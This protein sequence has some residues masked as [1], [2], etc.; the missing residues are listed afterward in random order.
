MT[1]LPFWAV[2]TPALTSIGLKDL[3][4]KQQSRH[5]SLTL[6]LPGPIRRPRRDISHQRSMID[7]CMRAIVKL[8]PQAYRVRFH[9]PLDLP[10]PPSH[11]RPVQRE[12]LQGHRF[13]YCCNLF[14]DLFHRKNGQEKPG[15]NVKGTTTDKWERI[16]I[17]GTLYCYVWEP[18]STVWSII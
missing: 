17:Q 18:I 2:T 8:P 13:L 11:V 3:D 15:L 7:L 5:W 12:V 16:R 9:V 1:L 6:P 4:Y 10:R 14:L